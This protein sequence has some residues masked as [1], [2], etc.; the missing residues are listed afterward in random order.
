MSLSSSA[1]C[2]APESEQVYVLGRTDLSEFAAAVDA[3]FHLGEEST[4]DAPKPTVEFI[5]QAFIDKQNGDKQKYVEPVACNAVGKEYTAVFDRLELEQIE[6]RKRKGHQN[7]SDAVHLDFETKTSLAAVCKEVAPDFKWDLPKYTDLSKRHK[8]WM[9]ASIEA[10]KDAE[11]DFVDD[12]SCGDE[13]DATAYESSSV[14]SSITVDPR[15]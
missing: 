8:E 10:A 4:P 14:Y 6:E 1:S 5:F 13:E 2:E 3:A 15:S 9:E 7:R 11:Y 12:S